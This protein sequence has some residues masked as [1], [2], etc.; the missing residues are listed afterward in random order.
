I[1]DK[2]YWDSG[3]SRHM[4]GNISYLSNFEPFDEGYVSFGQG[5]CKIKVDAGTN[6]TNLSGSGNPNPTAFVFNPPAEEME[7]LTVESPI[8]TVSSPVPTACLN[9]S[10]KP[11]S[12]ARL[13]SKRVANQEETPSLDNILSLTNRFEDILGVSTSSDEIIR[14]EADVSNLETS[15]SASPIPTLR[16]YKDHPKSQIIGPVDTPIQTRHKFKM[17]KEQ[18]PKKVSDALQDPSWVE[19]MQEEL[20]QFKIQKV[21][22][23]VDCPKEVT[24]IGTKWVLK[25]KKDERGIVVRN[26]ARLPPG[27]QDPT[28]PAK[29]YKVEKAMY[30]LHEA[31]RAWTGLERM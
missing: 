22:T 3:C 2:G 14:V 23:L 31:P 18:K 15:I 4:T 13:I 26:K 25:N 16:I 21:W 27:F 20:L 11:S 19:A 30:G 24:P 6:S 7:T 1:D 9:D 28:Y 29:V 17:V 5:G 10:S 12:E 8:P